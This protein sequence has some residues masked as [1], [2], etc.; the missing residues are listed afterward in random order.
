M[1]GG[2]H[3]LLQSKTDPRVYLEGLSR[4]LSLAEFFK[5]S[6]SQDELNSLVLSHSPG[7]VY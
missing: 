7:H 5:T 2:P 3:D 6:Q 4:A 1:V